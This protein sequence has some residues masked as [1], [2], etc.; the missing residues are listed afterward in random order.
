MATPKTRAMNLR[1][2]MRAMTATSAVGDATLQ[3]AIP[4]Q[5]TETQR[6]SR[7]VFWGREA[8]EQKWERRKG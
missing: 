6:F 4:R 5:K 2:T 7:A 8:R 1:A 3:G